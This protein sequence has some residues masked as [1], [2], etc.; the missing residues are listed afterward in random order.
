[1]TATD[2]PPRVP[3]AFAPHSAGLTWD[4]AP[5]GFSGA[6]VWRGR[7]AAGTARLALKA[8][9]RATAARLPRVHEWMR[10]AAHLPFVPEV[11]RGEGGGLVIEGDDV[12][13][14]CRW[15]PGAPLAHP[16][17]AEVARA[18]EAV[19]RLHGAWA[20]E[21]HRGP[22][23]GVRNRLAILRE[24]ADLLRAGPGALPPV[25][26]LL[27]PLLRRA[28]EV[29]ARAAPHAARALE[30]WADVPL[31]LQPCVRDLRADHVLFD[32]GAVRGVIDFGAAAVDHPAVDLARLLGDYGAHIDAGLAEYRAARPGFETPNELV[33][34]LTHTGLLGSALGWV[35]RLAVRRERAGS[36][37][38]V[39]ARVESLL[40]KIAR[41][42]LN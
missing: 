32:G 39:A 41:N 8:W 36:P 20:G 3:A 21:S 28:V 35:V 22:A 19:A 10:R 42:V 14:C 34:L 40:E 9:P 5:G 12:W 24:N 4:R 23:P 30:V 1:M 38:A 6:R 27:D 33:A 25:S 16:T 2:P 11:L 31:A 17:E 7:D 26:P 15:V 37:D 18:C 13:D 29:V